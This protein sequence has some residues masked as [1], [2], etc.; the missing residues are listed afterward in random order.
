MVGRG[1]IHRT[2]RD[3]G[4]HSD[5]VQQR[6]D[7]LGLPDGNGLDPKLAMEHFGFVDGVSQPVIEGTFR[8]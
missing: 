1:A 7:D 4:A 3:A 5:S 2:H 8:I 6:H